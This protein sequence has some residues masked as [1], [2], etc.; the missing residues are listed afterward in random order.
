VFHTQ[1]DLFYDAC[2][3]PGWGPY[4][5]LLAY[6]SYI[7]TAVFTLDIFVQIFVA[8]YNYED[9]TVTLDPWLNFK[10]Y[11]RWGC[12]ANLGYLD[13][14]NAAPADAQQTTLQTTLRT[15]LDSQFRTQALSIRRCIRPGKCRQ[16]LRNW[17]KCN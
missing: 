17:V 14:A 13:H 6:Q 3:H 2:T 7:L 1:F 15:A 4:T 5:D 16:L 11:C 8:H 12:I 10:L 9:H